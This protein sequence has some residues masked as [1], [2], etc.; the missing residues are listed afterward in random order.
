MYVSQRC[1]NTLTRDQPTLNGLMTKTLPPQM[2]QRFGS[3]TVL[4]ERA[5]KIKN[6]KKSM[7]TYALCKCD[8]GRIKAVQTHHLRNKS[9][10]RCSN[11]N[12]STKHGLARTY[13]ASTIHNIRQ[14]CNNPSCPDY[15]WYGA[16]GRECRLNGPQDIL[17]DI[18]HRPTPKHSVDRIDTEGHYEKGNIRW[19]TKPEQSRNMVSN[20][21]ITFG[22]KTLCLADWADELGIDRGSLWHRIQGAGWS[23]KRAFTTPVKGK[24]HTEGQSRLL[25]S[26]D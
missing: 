17:D 1:A 7:E 22:G 6:G 18:G 19:A 5:K 20:V 25:L 3:W 12:R 23:V 2:G 15:P 21:N 11:C 4:L 10:T 16:K 8:C 9:S 24:P 13:L 14:R 26:S